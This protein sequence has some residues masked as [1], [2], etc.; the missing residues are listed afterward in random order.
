MGLRAFAKAQA[1]NKRKQKKTKE[2]GGSKRGVRE[3]K[4]NFN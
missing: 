1:E 3:L 4:I 2:H